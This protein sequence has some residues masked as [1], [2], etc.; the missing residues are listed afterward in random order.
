VQS[1]LLWSGVDYARVWLEDWEV[2]ALGGADA[3]WVSALS[4]AGLR[5]ERARPYKWRMGTAE[6]WLLSGVGVA[7]RDDGAA[8]VQVPG[9]AGGDLLRK[10]GAFGRVS[11]IDVQVTVKPPVSR[12]TAIQNEWAAMAAHSEDWPHRGRAPGVWAIVGEAITAYSGKR[13]KEGVYLRVYDAEYVHGAE[14]EAYQGSVRYELEATGGRAVSYYKQIGGAEWTDERVTE[15]VMG[16]TGR[17][18]AT[19]KL[20]GVVPQRVRPVARA[21]E[22]SNENTLAW[23]RKQV[24]PSIERLLE[25]GVSRKTVLEALGLGEP[26]TVAGEQTS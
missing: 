3:V 13:S 6:G 10:L 9:A 15:A 26:V 11:R 22:K 18:G 7:V 25:D 21:G 23:I 8:I 16:E 12:E 24:K 2:R 4:I 5:S 19:L 1:Q 20:S 14:S 17:R